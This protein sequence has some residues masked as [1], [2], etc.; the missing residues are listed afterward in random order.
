MKTV[1]KRVRIIPLEKKLERMQAMDEQDL[2]KLWR[3]LKLVGDI[4]AVR[5]EL[6]RL[7]N[8]YGNI[9]ESESTLLYCSM[10]E[11]GSSFGGLLYILES[12]IAE[13]YSDLFNKYEVEFFEDLGITLPD[14]LL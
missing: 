8:V 13:E 4:N 6:I 10:E 9:V 14:E 7:T 11:V 5:K 1:R 3:L 12:D 2:S